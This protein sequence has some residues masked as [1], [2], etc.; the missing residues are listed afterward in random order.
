METLIEIIIASAWILLC[1]IV[2]LY[3]GFVFFVIMQAKTNEGFFINVPQE[4]VVTLEQGGA[5]DRFLHRGNNQHIDA[6]NG[7]FSKGA[8]RSS[9][10]SKYFLWGRIW[11]GFPSIVKVKEY[12]LQRQEWRLNERTNQQTLIFH[13][14][15]TPYL[16]T[17]PVPY[18][19]ILSGAEDKNG[20]ALD[21]GFTLYL[22]ARGSYKPFYGVNWCQQMTQ[23]ALGGA[24]DIVGNTTFDLLRKEFASD[25]Q[26]SE[27]KKSMKKL[28]PALRRLVEHEIV[29]VSINQI[30]PGGALA[31]EIVEALALN[32][33]SALR[34]QALIT[35][36]KGEQ[37]AQNLL[38][39]AKL[40]NM[41]ETAK[42]FA[43]IYDAKTKSVDGKFIALADAVAEH[44]GT[45][46]INS[47]S[48]T[49]IPLS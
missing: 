12:R 36:T 27:F 44:E 43:L 39:D 32:R 22:K 3:I 46:V 6:L 9:F 23:K 35:K 25:S 26:K 11:K 14:E 28:S 38:T 21:I 15:M 42:G 18:A 2:P 10:F 40:Y 5:H 7:T 47:P 45:L 20:F 4:Q 48:I 30:A 1:G 8:T 31:K 29:D 33:L 37:T 16:S 41:S 17:L 24:R 13:D 34:A 19:L 49:T